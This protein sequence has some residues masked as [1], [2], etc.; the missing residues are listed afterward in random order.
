M[1]EIHVVGAAILNGGKVLA[2]QRSIRMSAP[3]KWEFAGGKVEEGETHQ[4]ALRRE[5]SEELGV[6]I[7]V[8]DYLASGETRS[9]DRKVILHVYE[10]E[11]K[12][13]VPKAREHARLRWVDV[14]GLGQLD[15]A[16]ADIPACKE[17]MSR[18]GAICWNYSDGRGS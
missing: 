7:R 9:G 15:W 11:I 6:V 16:E 5:I 3:L 18:Y 10:A 2:A 8:K 12:E 4:D 1:Q 17:L 13:G 14:D